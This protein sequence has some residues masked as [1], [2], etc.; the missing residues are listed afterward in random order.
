MVLGHLPLMVGQEALVAKEW[1]SEGG[2]GAAGKRKSRSP[3]L[4]TVLLFIR[5][6]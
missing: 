2:A 4:G 5:N 6:M 3:Q 1:V